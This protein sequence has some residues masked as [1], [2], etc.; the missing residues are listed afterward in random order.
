MP[1][2]YKAY[3][4]PGNSVSQPDAVSVCRA[5]YAPGDTV[6]GDRCGEA[7]QRNTHWSSL[8]A[9]RHQLENPVIFFP[10]PPPDHRLRPL[11]W[12]FCA[13]ATGTARAMGLTISAD[14]E[15]AQPTPSGVPAHAD[16]PRPCRKGRGASLGTA[17]SARRQPAPVR[18]PFSSVP[19][20]LALPR[21]R[22]WR[23]CAHHDRGFPH[24]QPRTTCMLI[25]QQRLSVCNACQR[26][27]AALNLARRRLNSSSAG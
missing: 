5:I 25:G 6:M 19:S 20:A 23:R 12:M 9:H 15:R 7:R 3:S 26:G 13:F 11:P 1:G 17:Q 18:T 16:I 22:P 21:W 2:L 8:Y 27:L 4:S 24:A 14:A 10:A